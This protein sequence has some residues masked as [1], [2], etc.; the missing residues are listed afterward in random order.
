MSREIDR[1]ETKVG[2]GNRRITINYEDGS[3][4]EITERDDGGITVVD[5]DASGN[6][7]VGDGV[8]GILGILGDATRINRK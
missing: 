7:V 3:S 6:Q 1:T 5:T 4:R 8:T 2:G